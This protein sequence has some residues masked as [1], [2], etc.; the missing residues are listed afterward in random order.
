MT[1]ANKGVVVAIATE[2]WH[3]LQSMLWAQTKG[4]TD[5]TDSKSISHLTTPCVH[6][7][8]E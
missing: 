7:Q 4:N 1:N 2:T 8:Q 5:T 6:A 3:A